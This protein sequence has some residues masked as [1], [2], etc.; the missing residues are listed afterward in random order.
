M[1]PKQYIKNLYKCTAD[2]NQTIKNDQTL[3]IYIYEFSVPTKYSILNSLISG[4]STIQIYS[5]TERLT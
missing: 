4:M 5:N 1:K 2:N 3:S